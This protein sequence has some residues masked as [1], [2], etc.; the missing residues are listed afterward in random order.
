MRRKLRGELAAVREAPKDLRFRAVVRKADNAE[1]FC[2]IVLH[3]LEILARA[4][5]EEVPPLQR[6]GGK[7]GGDG[8][9]DVLRIH[10]FRDLRLVQQDGNVA[11]VALVPAV[12]VHVRRRA[13]HFRHKRRG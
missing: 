1:V 6:R 5:D 2:G 8:A 13:D 4:G 7:A 11:A 9:Q 12:V 10:I 3:V